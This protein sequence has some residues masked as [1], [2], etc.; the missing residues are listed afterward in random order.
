MAWYPRLNLRAFTAAT[1]MALLF[2]L[3]F[4]SMA[5]AHRPVFGQSGGTITL[6]EIQVSHAYYMEIESPG[7]VD[8]YVF[9]GLA[10]EHLHAGIV[11]PAIEGLEDF[12]VSMALLGPGLPA[13]NPAALPPGVDS[14]T[15]SAGM[16]QALVCPTETN[17]DFFEPFTQTNYWKRQTLE[18]DLPATGTYQLMIWNPEGQTGKY[19]LDV[20]TLEEF[21][22]GDLL[23]FPVW[24]LQVH[25]FFGQTEY[26]VSGAALVAILVGGLVVWLRRRRQPVSQ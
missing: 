17:D 12:G 19:V 14:T 11:I 8:T 5:S 21:G 3:V 6:D 18:T 2:T 4:T 9:E 20:G 13:V 23:V 24:W 7:Q 26:L 22:I 25:R 16:Q 15:D 1:V 10:G